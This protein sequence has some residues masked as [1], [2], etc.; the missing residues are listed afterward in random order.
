MALPDID[1]PSKQFDHF[2]QPWLNLGCFVSGAIILRLGICF[3]HKYDSGEESVYL[4][5]KYKINKLMV[6]QLT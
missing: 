3:C 2:K 1:M 6:R 5:L 4:I